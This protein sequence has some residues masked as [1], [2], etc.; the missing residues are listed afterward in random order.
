[1]RVVVCGGGVIG[2][3][4]AYYLSGAGADV[5]LV[6]RH[7]IAGAAS[8][9]SGGFLALDWCDGSE[10]SSL[11]RRSFQLHQALADA[12]GNP[13]GYRRLDTYSAI[14]GM[15]R[16]FGDSPA[17]PWLRADMFVQ[18]QLGSVE[19][20][21]QVT[22]AAFTCGMV[23]QAVAHGAECLTGEVTGILLDPDGS[24]VHGVEIDGLN[25]ET[26]AVVI[27]MG[28][29]SSLARRW[30]PMSDVHGL[31]G[32][33]VVFRPNEPVPA[34]ALFAEVR[35]QDGADWS[36]EIFPR[37]DGTVYLCGLPSF[38]ALPDD[39]GLVETN[40][41]ATSHLRSI[42]AALSPHL[43][44]AE[45]LAV[46]ACFR[47]VTGDGLP[48]LGHVPGV[49]GAYVATGHNVWGMLN[50]PAS[51]EAM[52]DLILLGRS[53]TIDL[54]AFDPARAKVS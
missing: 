24:R 40:E 34:D 44:D 45:I 1:M 3:C 32:H 4:L 12:H 25:R 38:E 31:K 54:T 37:P 26:E 14:A 19:T 16:P 53:E 49:D 39:P 22:P 50:A 33:S 15:E 46:G 47:P 52:A 36:P 51:G 11:A 13:W 7:R 28:P 35:G 42:A 2:A 9:K 5:L 6:E 29:W 48:L 21:A 41:Q 23:D 43:A 10:L 30:L 20:T 27:A 17:L 18:D 8:G